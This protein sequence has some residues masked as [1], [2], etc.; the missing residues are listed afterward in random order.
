MEGLLHAVYLALKH[1]SGQG[2]CS[3]VF[4]FLGNFQIIPLFLAIA[5]DA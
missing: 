2:S 3:M 5:H 1:A 4:T